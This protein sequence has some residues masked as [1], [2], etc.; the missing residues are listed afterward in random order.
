MGLSA[1]IG[2]KEYSLGS[3]VHFNTFLNNVSKIGDFPSLLQRSFSEG[4]V[5]IQYE[6]EPDLFTSSVYALLADCSELKRSGKLVGVD[7]DI[8]DSLIDICDAAIMEGKSIE[9]G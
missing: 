8:L 7:K 2:D 4:S 3:A 6:G 9:F 1:F 5:E